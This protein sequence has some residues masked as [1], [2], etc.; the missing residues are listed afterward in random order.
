MDAGIDEDRYFEITLE[1][2][3]EAVRVY[4]PIAAIQWDLL[5]RLDLAAQTYAKAINQ[6]PENPWHYIWLAV[7]YLDLGEPERASL[8][9]D[10]IDEL[11]P[12]DPVWVLL[13]FH[14]YQQTTEGMDKGAG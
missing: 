6:A 3:P 1:I 10:R 14:V 12:E 9:L 4:I 5:N 11:T 2:N 7:L 13:L 8:L